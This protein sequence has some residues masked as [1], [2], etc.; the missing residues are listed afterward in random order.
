MMQV[1]I[2]L[3]KFSVFTITINKSGKK[4]KNNIEKKKS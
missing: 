1:Q 3:A 4:D 2:R